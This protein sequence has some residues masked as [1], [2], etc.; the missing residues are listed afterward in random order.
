MNNSGK[1]PSYLPNDPAF[2]E[3]SELAFHRVVEFLRECIGEPQDSP[4]EWDSFPFTFQRV[5]EILV[6]IRTNPFNC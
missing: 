2:H 6:R 5:E 1:I 3:D 4:C